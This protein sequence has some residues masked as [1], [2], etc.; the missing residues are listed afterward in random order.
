MENDT[1]LD[2]ITIED[3]IYFKPDFPKQIINESI[4]FE[5]FKKRKLKEYG[6]D[7]KLFHCEIDNIYFYES[8]E[9][10]EAR[11][12]YNKKCPLCNKY[13][14]YFC[15]SQESNSEELYSGYCC[16]KLFIHNL[17]FYDAKQ[18]LN[19]KHFDMGIK[20]FRNI[21]ILSILPLTGFITYYILFFNILLFEL[22]I[23][24]SPKENK[25]RR[26]NELY[27]MDDNKTYTDYYI[28]TFNYFNLFSNLIYFSGFALSI[29]YTIYDIYFKILFLIISLLTKFYPFKYFIGVMNEGIKFIAA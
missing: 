3:D 9:N 14:C 5:K 2:N 4:K 1:R 26:K 10:C 29:C 13:I 15:K 21:T 18:Y 11:P 28:Y 23:K 12:Y 17:L 25:L 27:F 7:A 20:V 16:I 6:K 24:R 8:E 22:S 19:G